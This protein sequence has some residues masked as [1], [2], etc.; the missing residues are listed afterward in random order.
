MTLGTSKIIVLQ[1]VKVNQNCKYY[2][3]FWE[4]FVNN[5]DHLRMFY[6]FLHRVL[7]YSDIFFQREQLFLKKY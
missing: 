5:N 7:Y 4:N 2:D 6:F 1:N 3:Y